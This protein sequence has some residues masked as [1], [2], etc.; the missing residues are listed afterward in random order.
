[1]LLEKAWFHLAGIP[2]F[3]A[4]APRSDN[5]GV[6][7]LLQYNYS[8]KDAQVKYGWRNSSLDLHVF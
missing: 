3:T 6:S 7:W 2:C 8:T 4:F 5:D 1:V